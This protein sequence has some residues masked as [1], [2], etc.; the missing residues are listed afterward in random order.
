[1]RRLKPKWIV[2]AMIGMSAIFLAFNY[3][4]VEHFSLLSFNPVGNAQSNVPTVGVFGQQL[5]S[6][7]VRGLSVAMWLSTGLV[8]LVRWR[9]GH[10]VLGQGI[11]A[12]SAFLLLGGQGYGGEAIFRVFLYS[13]FGCALILAPPITKMMSARLPWTALIT[14]ALIGAV[15]ASAQGFYGSWFANKMSRAQ[16]TEAHALL[17]TAAYPGYL[18]VAAPVWPERSNARYVPYA[19]WT[20]PGAQTYDYP[21]IY[22]AKLVGTDFSTQAEYDQFIK[23]VQ[24]RTAPTYLIITRQMAIYDWYFGI[25]PLNAL[26]NLEGQ[27]RADKRW[28]VYK[29]T[30]EY[31]I[32]KTTPALIGAS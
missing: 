20:P 8:F 14:I 11:L 9:R 22:A 4:S 32:F 24:V 3:D 23:L 26:D 7:L 6:K 25:L 17:N 27:M 30:S 19:E 16:V 10:K 5:T 1:M 21:M 29:D 31:V 28:T 2:Y 15:G 13:L 12:F 18:T